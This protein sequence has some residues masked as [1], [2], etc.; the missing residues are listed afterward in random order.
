MDV[1]A[2]PLLEYPLFIFLILFYEKAGMRKENEKQ[3][4]PFLIR[5]LTCLFFSLLNRICIL[6]STICMEVE[7]SRV[8]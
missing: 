6:L 8:V 1:S 5:I 2:G 7:N 4:Y 3:D